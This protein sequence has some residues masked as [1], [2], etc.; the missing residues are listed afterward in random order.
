ML[1][2]ILKQRILAQGSLSIAE[3]MAEALSY[4]YGTRDPLGKKGDFTTAPE[5]SQLFGEMIGVWCAYS[6]QQMGCPSQL[7]LIELGPGRGTLM[8][9]ILRSTRKVKGF[10]EALT[11]HMVETS[12]TLKQQ[13]ERALV[14]Y[15]VHFHDTIT[16]IPTSDFILVANE[17]FDAL[18]IHQYHK[19]STG[20]M[21]RKITFSQEQ[22]CFCFTLTPLPSAIGLQL[23]KEHAL[24][25][26]DA[27][28]ELCPAALA[29][30]REIA[31]RLTSHKGMA[32]IID[33][34]YDCI[35]YSDTL[36]AVKSHQYQ[37]ILDNIGEADITAH[38][39]FSALKKVAFTMGST[40]FG[41]I[42]QQQL[43]EALGIRLRAEKLLQNADDR[44]KNTILS[45]LN[46]LISPQEMGALFKAISLASPSL[47]PAGF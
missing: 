23:E 15:P 44:Q 47:T 22:E 25:P 38:V 30:I 32:L 37:P 2:D 17:F 34:G 5:I 9:D 45:G 16:S 14:G 8:A 39:D 35:S 21:E 13:Q 28:L 24:A 33:Y 1:T 27:I 18:P 29:V 11:V 20:W 40:S 43:L 4:Y 41:A 10:H 6:W 12:P 7:A 3:F 26:I 36:Q 42:T 31:E 19:T 46:R